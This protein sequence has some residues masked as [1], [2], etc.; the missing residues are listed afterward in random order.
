MSLYYSFTYPCLTYCTTVWSSAYVTNLN[1][2]FLHQKR[3]VRALTNSNPHLAPS[4][5]SFAD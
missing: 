4:A 5:P 2:I 3:A 1:R